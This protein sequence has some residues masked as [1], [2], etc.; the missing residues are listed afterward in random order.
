M[1]T[2]TRWR[3]RATELLAK[4]ANLAITIILRFEVEVMIY[5]GVGKVMVLIPSS[6]VKVVAFISK[7]VRLTPG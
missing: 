6:R 1:P 2:K 7:V 5:L 4:L 3:Q